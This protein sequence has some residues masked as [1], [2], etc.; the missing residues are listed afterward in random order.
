MA[1]EKDVVVALVAG[2]LADPT[3]S[4][5]DHQAVVAKAINLAKEI[6]F[7][8]NEANPALKKET[9]AELKAEQAE[10]KAGEK[11]ERAS[12]K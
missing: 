8:V 10:A 2:I 6:D 7:Q 12:H 9:A 4:S 3:T 11:A 5:K 1:I